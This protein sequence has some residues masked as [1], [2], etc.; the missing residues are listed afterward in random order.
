[1][2][3]EFWFFS[4]PANSRIW[5]PPDA[6]TPKVARRLI[7]T[8]KNMVRLFW[9]RNGFYVNR[10]LERGISFNSVYFSDYVISDIEGL[11]TL[12]TAVQEKEFVL[13]M[14]NS[15]VHSSR[16][17]TEKVASLRLVLASHPH[18]RR[19]WYRLISFSS[20]TWKRKWSELISGL[21]G[22]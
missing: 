15:P 22:N 19:I 5:L 1:M 4:C 6:E 8:P 13:Q 20:D 14:G 18:I 16:T 2:D 17:V 7:N 10:F 3:D 9:N 21:C 11:P 12:R